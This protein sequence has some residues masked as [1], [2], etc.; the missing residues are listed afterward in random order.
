MLP[1]PCDREAPNAASWHPSALHSLS[2]LR[3][4]TLSTWYLVKSMLLLPHVLCYLSSD[5]VIC[6]QT[7]KSSNLVSVLCNNPDKDTAL[8]LMNLDLPRCTRGQ[9]TPCRCTPY[10]AAFDPTKYT[11]SNT[12]IGWWTSE[13]SITG[14][15]PWQSAECGLA[16]EVLIGAD[17]G[18]LQIGQ[19]IGASCGA[20][21]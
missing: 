7:K 20:R 13:T 6:L 2:V 3:Y 12:L 21:C 4:I 10:E 1:W 18:L 15:L 16:R 9:T 17:L 11:N 14:T 5:F 8:D 19:Y